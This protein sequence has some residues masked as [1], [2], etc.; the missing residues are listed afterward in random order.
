MKLRFQCALLRTL[1]LPPDSYQKKD[2]SESQWNKA[3][4]MANF[5][6]V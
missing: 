2:H 5:A 1:P 4:K 6:N 3:K